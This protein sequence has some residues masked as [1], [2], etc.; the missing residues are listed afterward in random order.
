MKQ[1]KQLS[2][3]KD[4]RK[5]TKLWW[6]KKQNTYGGSFNYRKV[7]RPFDSKKL[8]HVVFKAKLGKGIYFTKSQKSIENLIK[9]VTEKYQVKIREKSINKDH[10]HLLVWTN[11][12]DH[13]LKFLRLFSAEMGRGY[14][15]IFK[16]FGLTKTKSLW[17][18]RPFTRLVSWGKTSQEIV[19]KYIQKNTKEVL[20]FV[21][22]TPRRHRVNVFIKKWNEQIDDL[23]NGLISRHRKM[24]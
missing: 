21:E 1:V 15:E 12:R 9:I 13:F 3:I 6:I 11:H 8:V 20:G 23:I 19:I 17:I 5:N 14:K 22:Y 24:A 7:E 16:R 4:P 2:L 18:A 10:I